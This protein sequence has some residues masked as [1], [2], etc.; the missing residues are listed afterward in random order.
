VSLFIRS[1]ASDPFLDFI[2]PFSSSFPIEF[3]LR[4]TPSEVPPTSNMSNLPVD[5][6]SRRTR[7]PMFLLRVFVILLVS[8]FPADA[9]STGSAP[10][11]PS[12]KHVNSTT[13][14]TDFFDF[15]DCY[16]VNL[17]AFISNNI[18]STSLSTSSSSSRSSS[19]SS[20]SSSSQLVDTI[21]FGFWY[22]DICQQVYV[23]AYNFDV[24]SEFTLSEALIADENSFAIQPVSFNLSNTKLIS[25]VNLTSDG[26]DPKFSF[27]I[28]NATF[29][30]GIRYSSPSPSKIL[31][32][33]AVNVTEQATFISS[34]FQSLVVFRAGDNEILF[35]ADPIQ[36][37]NNV[38]LSLSGDVK[39][40]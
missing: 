33:P 7:L 10:P 24:P 3:D 22:T 27:E 12:T 21:Y 18:S 14:Y 15:T 40:S 13:I 6:I 17:R 29:Y 1:L 9:A 39:E 23:Q 8:T 36:N 16:S 35:V 26:S 11:K 30:E 2:S 25:N 31:L 19:G 5:L 38:V 20:S 32:S 37:T 4:S 28:R 34:Y